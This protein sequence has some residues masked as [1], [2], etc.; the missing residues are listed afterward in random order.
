MAFPHADIHKLLSP[1]LLHQIIKGTFKDHIID[2]IEE[3]INTAYGKT[4]A[5]KILADIDR[6][7]EISA[8][9]TY[10]SFTIYLLAGSL[11]CHHSQVCVTFT[12]AVS[13]NNGWEMT[14]RVS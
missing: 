8:V 10:F 3:Y 12:W 1:D 6:Q 2:W 7:C 9:L 4:E 14:Q 13:S 11:W 5:A